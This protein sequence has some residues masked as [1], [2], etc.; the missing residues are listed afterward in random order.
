MKKKVKKNLNR[1][2][3]SSFNW[4]IYGIIDALR[5][6]PHLRFHFVAAVVVIIASFVLGLNRYEWLAVVLSIIIVI[7][8]EMVNTLIERVCNRITALQDI[9]IKKIKD[10][11]AGMVL[12]AAI[13]A[14]VIGYVVFYP[15]LKSLW[16]GRLKL[17][18]PF[19]IIILV[20]V[21]IVLALVV[22]IKAFVSPEKEPLYG[23]MPSGHAAIAFS[24][25]TLITVKTSSLIV[26]IAAF[27]VALMVVESRLSLGIHKISEVVAGILL[28][29][30]ISY[31][32]YFIFKI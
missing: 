28:G 24:L 6:E 31:A 13:G 17:G 15:H 16:D 2:P 29:V 20:S 22:I 5:G 18:I 19:H 10:L 21:I 14:S 30:T 32:V 11:S 9:E 12:I 3:F 27:L 8:A 23:G 7:F 1:L 25:W 26:S 4:A